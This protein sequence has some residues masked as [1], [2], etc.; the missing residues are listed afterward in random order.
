MNGIWQDLRFGARMLRK[1]PGFTAAAVLSLALG[2]GANTAIFQLLDAVRLKT[3][4][5][6]SPH[7]LTEVR[8]VDMDKARGSFSWRH[9]AVTNSIWEQI[10]DRQQAFSGIFAWAPGGFNLAQGGEVRVGRALWVSGNFFGVLGVQPLLGRVLTPSDDTKDCT[11]PGLVISHG[12]WQREFG[13]ASDVIGRKLT[14]ADHSLEI[15]GVTP[16]DFFGLEVGRN[17]DF[18]LPICA[19][20]ALR[21]KNSR[22]DSGTSW[23]LMVTGRLKPGWSL[24][25]AN[26]SLQSMSAGLFQTTLPANYPPVSVNDYLGFKLEAVPAASGYSSLRED[27][28]RPLWLLLAIAGLV[29]IIACANL[30]NL[31]MA[32]AS[33]REREMAVR[34]AVGASRARLVRQLL[35]ESLLLALIGAGLGALLAQSLSRFL[36][37]FISTSGDAIFLDLA[38]DWRM[39]GFAAAV[40]GRRGWHRRAP[41]HA[42]LRPVL[43]RR[44]RLI[45]SKVVVGPAPVDRLVR[46]LVSLL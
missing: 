11:A 43:G 12:F 22:L 28:E 34:Q 10:R 37:S 30:A 19:E 33:T 26:S 39:L 25:Q 31:L 41:N 3:L 23:W 6:A 21:G 24:A 36:V 17:F 1:S 27:Y 35:A 29:L 40:G 7:E 5:V 45:C 13:G 18:A 38:F 8:I 46:P 15:I 14:L 4:P 20:K 42:G 16:P 9:H 44:H 2:I 32:R